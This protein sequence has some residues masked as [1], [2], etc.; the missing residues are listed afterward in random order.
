[1][2]TGN[3]IKSN[4][5]IFSAAQMVGDKEFKVISR[6]TYDALVQQAF[7]AFALTTYFDEQRKDIPL[8]G[9]LVY[10]LPDDCFNVKGIYI[11]TGDICNITSSRKLWW[12]R[13]YFTKGNGY[14]ADNKG[15]NLNDPFFENNSGSRQYG[16]QAFSR[17]NQGDVNNTLFY[18][19][20][21]GT[22]MISSA[23]IG[24]GSKLH[25]YY[26]GTGCPIGEAPIIPIYL[27]T[28]M[29]DYVTEAALRIRMAS[30]ADPRRWQYL[31]S[32]YDKRLNAPYTGSWEK[33]QYLVKNMNSSQRADLYE[34]LG[35]GAWA[36][37]F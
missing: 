23:C 12:K 20:Q 37:G 11:F 1:M 34:Y 17:L 27:R 2:N 36:N 25:I 22:L 33:A 6:G 10:N 15:N 7:E 3:F 18:N 16:Q 28:A 9:G 24:L 32:V 13:N 29:E 31:Q 4:I 21:Q 26:N 8:N 19:F 5:I 35:R 30:D 14:I